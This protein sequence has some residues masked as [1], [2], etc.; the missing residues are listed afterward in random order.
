MK[1]FLDLQ[2]EKGSKNTIFLLSCQPRVLSFVSLFIIRDHDAAWLEGF[3][4]GLISQITWVQVPPPLPECRGPFSLQSREMARQVYISGFQFGLLHFIHAVFGVNCIF[5]TPR[6]RGALLLFRSLAQKSPCSIA[7]LE[8][9]TYEIEMT[10]IFLSI[11]AGLDLT[12]NSLGL[13][14]IWARRR[15]QMCK[16][17]VSMNFKKI[18]CGRQTGK[19]PAC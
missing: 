11:P 2:N 15:S 13:L 6:K 9:I 8:K 4:A 16:S 7:I 14:H 5:N 17:L 3:Q 1:Y 10:W 18:V 12:V 19:A